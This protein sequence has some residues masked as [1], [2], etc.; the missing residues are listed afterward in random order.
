MV[1]ARRGHF[2]LG[3]S[4]DIYTRSLLKLEGKR[5]GKREKEGRKRK[6]NEEKEALVLTRTSRNIVEKLIC[7]IYCSSIPTQAISAIMA[8]DPKLIP[9]FDGTNSGQSV[10]E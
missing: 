3:E 9:L 7:E 1:T 6:G 4:I 2:F 10:V 8:F 5:E